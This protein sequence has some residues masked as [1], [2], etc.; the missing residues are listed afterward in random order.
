V[1]LKIFHTL[2]SLTCEIYFIG[3][4][5]TCDNEA[6]GY[7]ITPFPNM[8]GYVPLRLQ[9]LDNMVVRPS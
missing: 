8:M 4:S 6:K 7:V 5:N 3:A 9:P 1:Y 2:E